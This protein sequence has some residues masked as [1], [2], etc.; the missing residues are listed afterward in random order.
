MRAVAGSASAATSASAAGVRSSNTSRGR[1]AS[2]ARRA[3]LTTPIA[4][5]LSPPSAKKSSSAPTSGSPSTSANIPHSA[6]SRGVRARRPTARCSRCR[7]SGRAR[8]STLPFGVS[9]N[10][11]STVTVLGTMYSGRRSAHHRRSSSSVTAPA[12]RA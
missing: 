5:M 7:G 8:R 6:C 10:A 4:T 12:A 3:L 11:S 2:P 9:G 1:T